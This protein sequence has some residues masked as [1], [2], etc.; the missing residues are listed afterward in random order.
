MSY[1]RRSGGSSYG[2]QRG[3]SGFSGHRK[4]KAKVGFGSAQQA[5][6]NMKLSGDHSLIRS[7]DDPRVDEIALEIQKKKGI[8]HGDVDPMTQTGW[9]RRMEKAGMSETELYEELDKWF[10][11]SNPW[12]ADD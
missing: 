6:S 3:K 10:D 4:G 9:E 7:M 12:F 1:G 2:N 5:I 11:K 8:T